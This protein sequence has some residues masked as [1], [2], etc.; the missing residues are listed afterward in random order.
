MPER[1]ISDVEIER[2][3]R[4]GRSTPAKRGRTAFCATFE[5]NGRWRDR[6]YR[7]KEVTAIAA[8]IETGWLVITVIAKYF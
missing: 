4:E 8:P 3:V 7:S 1:G 6:Y 5:Y 2:V